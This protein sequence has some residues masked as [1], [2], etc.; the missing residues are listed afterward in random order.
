MNRRHSRFTLF[1]L[2]AAVCL[3]AAACGSGTGSNTS[4][5][6]ANSFA[7]QTLTVAEGPPTEPGQTQFNQSIASQFKKATGA[8]LKYDYNI[9]STSVELELISA[10][11]VS[12]SGP[13]VL[14]FGDT[15]NA[16][17]YQSSGFQMLSKS[18]WAML[19]GQKAFWPVTM[20]NSGPT[21][22]KTTMVPE[23][24]DPTLMV[25]NKTLFKQA[26]IS[27]PPTTWTEYVQD[28]QKINDPSKGIYGTDWFPND[29]QVYKA[30]WYFG[31]DYGGRVFSPNLKT[32]KLDTQPWLQAL[33]FWFGLQTQYNIVP[34]NSQNNTQAEF[35]AQFA[36]GNIGEEVA[37]TGSYEGTYEAGKIGKDFAFAPLPTT[38]YGQAPTKAKLPRSMDLYEGMVIAKSAP[39][40]LAMQYLKILTSEQNELLRYKLG[41]FVPSKITPAKAAA[42]LDPAL[43][44]PQ[45][46]AEEGAQGVP[47]TPAWSTF[48][49]AIGTVTI[50]AGGY[51]A[52]HGNVPNS[53]F[54]QL[55]SQANST[56]QAKL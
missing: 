14:E 49:T 4:S 9:T 51:L 55:L 45:I 11:A 10:A 52:Q 1:T 56:V 24:V 15:I 13:D 48:Q 16:A 7:G 18:D 32:A 21:P 17:A 8:T 30:M 53:E 47:F 19:G 22:K 3:L 31:T 39:H 23:Y 36:N 26:G 43:I 33:Q 44:D 54:K 37:A 38:P 40:A 20:Q 6:K 34:P 5:G 29:T 42:K 50:D 12:N 28:A 35:A 46:T 2:S 27:G 25:Y 41:G